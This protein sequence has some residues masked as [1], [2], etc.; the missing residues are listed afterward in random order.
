MC[1]TTISILTGMPDQHFILCG[2]RLPCGPRNMATINRAEGD[3]S[4]K[5]CRRVPISS[6]NVISLD[7]DERRETED[8]R[9]S[10]VSDDGEYIVDNILPNSRD[11]VGSIYRGMD[12]WWKQMYRI[13]DRN[14]SK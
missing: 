14:E 1:Y 2:G 6:A 11:C 12:I 8:H 4:G 3:E 10:V 9:E 5:P 7:G 13:A